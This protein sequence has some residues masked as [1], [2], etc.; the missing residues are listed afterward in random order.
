MFVVFLVFLFLFVETNY[1]LCGA[2]F[3]YYLFIII[4]MVIQNEKEVLEYL[5]IPSIPAKEWDGK[6]SFKDGVAV[7]NVYG[8]IQE[9]AVATFDADTDI[10]PRIKKVFGTNP[11]YDIASIYVVPNYMAKE[12]D[13]KDFDL[14][15][16]SKKAAED[17]LKEASELENDGVVND[18]VLPENPWFFDE[19]H[20]LDEAVAW[21]R[22]YN[23][24]NKI[25]GKIPSNE[26]TIKLRLLT[27]WKDEQKRLKSK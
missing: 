25:R 12:E 22:R 18:E 7:V 19:I 15:D 27:I 8:G 3:I 11:F 13:V 26:E 20:N 6:S 4:A 10:N 14:D 24:I 9:Y 5:R 21:L 2:N 16:E 17:L 1:Y 23:S